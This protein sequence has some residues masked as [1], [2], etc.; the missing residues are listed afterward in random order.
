MSDTRFKE[1]ARERLEQA[2]AGLVDDV[3][4]LGEVQQA[5]LALHLLYGSTEAFTLVP[6]DITEDVEPPKPRCICPPALVARGGFR[7]GCPI[8]HR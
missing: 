8:H 3:E 6:T 5:L 1:Y 7:S 2:L 4:V